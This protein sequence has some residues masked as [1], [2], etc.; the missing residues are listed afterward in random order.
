[1]SEQFPTS[2]KMVKCSR[3]GTMNGVDLAYCRKCDA[4]LSKKVVPPPFPFGWWWSS[5]A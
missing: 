5:W 2:Y 1:M 4:D 3:C